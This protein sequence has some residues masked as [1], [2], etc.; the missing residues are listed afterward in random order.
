[1]DYDMFK[2]VFLL[3]LSFAGGIFY[4]AVAPEISTGAWALLGSLAAIVLIVSLILRKANPAALLRLALLTALC[5]SIFAGMTWFYTRGQ[6]LGIVTAVS[7]P[8][9]L[10]L[11][12]WGLRWRNPKDA[13]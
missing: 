1:M 4:M 11:A 7:A 8:V 3:F 2:L 10:G 6:R 13:R 5:L 12:I 9:A